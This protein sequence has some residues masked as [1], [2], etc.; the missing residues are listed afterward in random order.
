MEE[1]EKINEKPEEKKEKKPQ[2]RRVRKTKA[3]LQ[4]CLA[5][6]MK[7]KRINEITVKEL[8]A[9]SDLNRGTFYLHYND[10]FD[11]LEQTETEL[12]TE[13]EH[14]LSKFD[15]SI[16]QDRPALVLQEVF[17]LIKENK[18]MVS[19]LISDNGDLNFVMALRQIVEKRCLSSMMKQYHVKNSENFNFFF[20]FLLSGSIGIVQYWI[21]TNCHETPAELARLTEQIYQKGAGVLD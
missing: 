1:T 16:S 7:T 20:Q 2:D 8:T 18:D 11:L 19:V 10:V 6:L 4:H 14:A 3:Q 9:M 5:E 15:I 13:F 12:L 21:Q 17:T